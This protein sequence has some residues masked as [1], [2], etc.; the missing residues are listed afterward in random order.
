LIS[1]PEL[2]KNQIQIELEW[3]EQR[4]RALDDGGPEHGV[5]ILNLAAWHE[6]QQEPLKALHYYSTVARE[7]NHLQ[8]T[9]A[10]TRL[11]AAPILAGLGDEAAALRHLWVAH[12]IFDQLEFASAAHEAGNAWLDLALNNVDYE[13]L[14]MADQ[15]E[16]AQPRMPGQ[17]RSR[18]SV[19]PLDYT[20][21]ETSLQNSLQFLNQ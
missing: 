16:Q 8:E 2:D 5:A 15:I 17:P 9:V 3:V 21:M 6:L 19:S 7:G 14:S 1:I 13:S 20:K 10:M 4:L 12:D 11:R 18:A